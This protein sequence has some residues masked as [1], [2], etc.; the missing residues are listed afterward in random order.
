VEQRTDVS[1]SGDGLRR[2]QVVGHHSVHDIGATSTDSDHLHTVPVTTNIGCLAGVLSRS[3]NL[4][5]QRQFGCGRY[6][7]LHAYI[8]LAEQMLAAWNVVMMF[9]DGE[10]CELPLM[11]NSSP[12]P[13]Q[14]DFA[15]QVLVWLSHWVI[16]R[17]VV[18]PLG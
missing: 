9:P 11:R 18:C 4:G 5:C 15:K 7:S 1:G 10:R 17:R 12:H 6:V 3:G 2:L 14:G 16:T 8:H 13:W